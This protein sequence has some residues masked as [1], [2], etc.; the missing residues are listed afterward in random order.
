MSYSE[1]SKAFSVSKGTLSYM[2][3][4]I[5][6]RK[7]LQDAINKR[8]EQNQNRF[9]EMCRGYEVPIEAR[10]RGGRR[11]HEIYGDR[12]AKNL[13]VGTYYSGLTYRLDELP[14]K[15]RLEKEY[16][17]SFK[18]EMIGGRYFDFCSTDHVIEFTLSIS[19]IHDA[20]SRFKVFEKIKDD[21]QRIAY[22]RLNPSS[23]RRS[24]KWFRSF[25]ALGVKIIHVKNDGSF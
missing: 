16:G 15:K 6:L 5:V 20:L 8:C 23:C 7:D 24:G 4:N 10:R 13:K 21:R 25:E 19:G 14:V 17:V 22:I 3:R 18:K 12:I 11:V 9:A 1:I 2:L